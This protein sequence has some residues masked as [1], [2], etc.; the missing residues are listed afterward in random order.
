MASPKL[1]KTSLA[2][3]VP[4]PACPQCAKPMVFGYVAA[5]GARLRWV[6]RPNTKTFFAGEMLS[7][8]FSFWSAPSYE[9]YRCADCGLVLLSYDPKKKQERKIDEE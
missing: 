8:P 7:I 9:A 4:E 2:D 3:K 1:R 6:D 5:K